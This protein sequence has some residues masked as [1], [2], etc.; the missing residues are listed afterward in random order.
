MRL[1]KYILLFAMFDLH[2]FEI[3]ISVWFTLLPLFCS[4]YQRN[5]AITG[6]LLGKT[7]FL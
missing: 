2:I 5:T 6:G 3:Q 4:Y 7:M 1:K